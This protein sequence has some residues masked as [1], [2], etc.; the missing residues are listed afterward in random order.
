MFIVDLDIVSII[1]STLLNPI[2]TCVIWVYVHNY[3][4][5]I[6]HSNIGAQLRG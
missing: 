6:H 5:A 4:Q 2:G 3:K 1:L